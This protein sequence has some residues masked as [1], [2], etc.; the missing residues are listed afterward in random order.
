MQKLLFLLFFG[1]L[2]ANIS[3][4]LRRETMPILDYKNTAYWQSKDSIW[5]F[6]VTD[7]FKRIWFKGVLVE[8]RVLKTDTFFIK[9]FAKEYQHPSSITQDNKFLGHCFFHASADSIQIESNDS[10]KIN[11]VILYRKVK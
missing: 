8:R 9:G 7:T 6:D 2:S 4:F 3:C 10:V 5:R 11:T 1:C